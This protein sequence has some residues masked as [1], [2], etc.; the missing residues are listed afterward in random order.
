MPLN[1]I[2]FD[3]DGLILDTE[4]PEVQAWQAIFR[5]NG[6]E[7]PDSYWINA[8]GRG[9]DQISETPVQLLERLTG[10]PVDHVAVLADYELRRFAAIEASNTL[11]GVQELILEARSARLGLAV[12]SSSKHSWVDRQLQRLN[13]FEFFDAILCA[14]DVER[15]KPFPDLYLATCEALATPQD[16][17]MALED[18]PN[19]I[20]A[21]KSA[22]LYCLA[23]PNPCTVQLS[24]SEADQIVASLS[25]VSLLNLNTWHSSSEVGGSSSSDPKAAAFQAIIEEMNAC[26]LWNIAPPSPDALENM[27]PF[28]SSTMSFGQWLRHV[29]VPRVQSTLESDGPWPSQSMVGTQA[30]REFDGLD[31]YSNLVD[32][33]CEFDQLF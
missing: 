23:V 12:A 27:G 2:I 29:F 30:I 9:A 19:G 15:A 33:L 4:T 10:G 6:A 32:R 18:S 16:Q 3:F 22:G 24:L 25:G 7:F 28:G 20:R 26:G 21:A 1:A 17:C 31:E 11:P 8:I 5:E 14:D 13:L